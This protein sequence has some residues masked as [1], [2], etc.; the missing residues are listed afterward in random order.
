MSME[1]TADVL[2]IGAGIAGLT[3]AMRLKQANICD[4]LVLDAR[5]RIGGRV[6][7]TMF[8]GV[9][10]STGPMYVHGDVNT[11]VAHLV[12]QLKLP[13]H[14]PDYS[15]FGANSFVARLASSGEV[16]TSQF[17]AVVGKHDEAL[18]KLSTLSIPPSDVS[19]AAEDTE[20]V[21]S[22]GDG[23]RSN[24]VRMRWR[25]KHV[26]VTVPP[27]LLYPLNPLSSV[28]V[29]AHISFDPP[30]PMKKQ[31]ALRLVTLSDYCR[32]L[33]AYQEPFW[34]PVDVIL[35]IDDLQPANTKWEYVD[36]HPARKFSYWQNLGNFTS[37]FEAGG[38]LSTVLSGYWAEICSKMT[39]EELAV[40]V[41]DALASMY[42]EKAAMAK[43][44][45]EVKFISWKEDAF[46]RGAFATALVGFN[47]PLETDLY[48]SLSAGAGQVHFAGD[49]Y[50]LDYLGSVQ[51]AFISALDAADKIAE[52]LS[53]NPLSDHNDF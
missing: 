1:R 35:R 42:P 22:Q 2:I 50:R 16:V 4:L 18:H 19:I 39:M 6:A 21:L 36:S 23:Y 17:A 3:A 7:T 33:V 14:P 31:E 10:L 46:S 30:L 32:V 13:V 15:Q 53:A 11:P 52:S 28:G 20:Y 12:K 9:E 27:V 45:L 43:K 48:S 5:E 38:V 47:K 49:G 8:R 26:L 44:P 37:G 25:A 51:G 34:D 40:E 24:G 41:G 29:D